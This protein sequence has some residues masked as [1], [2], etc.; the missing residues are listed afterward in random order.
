[1]REA[2]LGKK[3]SRAGAHSHKPDVPCEE[4]FPDQ[5]KRG[6]IQRKHS[7]TNMRR[8]GFWGCVYID[9]IKGQSFMAE[10]PPRATV[11]QAAGDDDPQTL[12]VSGQDSTTQQLQHRR[13]APVN[14]QRS[15]QMCRSRE[16][17]VFVLSENP[18]SVLAGKSESEFVW[19]V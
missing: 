11:P 2:R 10:I 4:D 8:S 1:M 13:V 15:L 17:A 12:D 19:V 7:G 5:P 14:S 3:N 6:H 9:A 16:L 18:P